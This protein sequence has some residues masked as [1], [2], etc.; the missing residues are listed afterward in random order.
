[1]S[2]ETGSAHCR[3]CAL[4]RG[5]RAQRHADRAGAT[6]TDRPDAVP[7]RGD[8]ADTSAR[9]QR[10]PAAWLNSWDDIGAGL[11]RRPHSAARKFDRSERFA[12]RPRNR[13]YRGKN[14]PDLDGG[15][16]GV[17]RDR[18]LLLGKSRSSI[19]Q[20]G[21][22]PLLAARLFDACSPSLP[23]VAWNPDNGRGRL[24]G[25]LVPLLGALTK[26]CLQIGRPA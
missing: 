15:D 25:G 3:R 19:A 13:H 16:W 24:L 1:M 21:G 12:R 2:I 6:D 22:A 14:G 5:A 17:C 18:D 20:V 11:G 26:G 4:R 7:H 9:G 10:S 23:L 8:A